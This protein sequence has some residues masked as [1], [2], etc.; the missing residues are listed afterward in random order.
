MGRTP[1][2]KCCICGKDFYAK[3]SQIRTNKFGLTCSL[4]CCREHKRRI[5][6]LCNPTHMFKKQCKVCG[7]EYETYDKNSKYCSISCATKDRYN[8]A[9]VCGKAFNDLKGEK[10][11]KIKDIR[12]IWKNMVKRCLDSKFKEKHPCY[13]DVSICDEWL[14]FS[15]FY[16]WAYPLYKDRYSLDKDI[17]CGKNKKIYS[18]DTCCFIPRKINNSITYLMNNIEDENI[19]IWKSGSKFYPHISI[20]NSKKNLGVYESKEEAVRVRKK[21]KKDFILNLAN[22]YKDKIDSKVYT[23]LL[24]LFE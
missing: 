18:P 21:A 4:E 12:Y 10:L 6:P 8:N 17:L 9:T 7:S 24:S 14:I 16:N 22:E 19:G 15:N 23:A 20:N 1:N 13:K 11:P 2:S 3:P 5:S